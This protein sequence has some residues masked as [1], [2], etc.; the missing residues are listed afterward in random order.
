MRVRAAQVEDLVPEDRIIVLGQTLTVV[1]VA[2]KGG[3]REIYTREKTTPII[4][5]GSG[6]VYVEER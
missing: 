4:R 2:D 5:V 3:L 6:L 1:F